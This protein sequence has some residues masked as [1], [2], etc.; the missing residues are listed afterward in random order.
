MNESTESSRFTDPT[1]AVDHVRRVARETAAAAGH[2]A[3]ATAL[4]RVRQEYRVMPL[5]R[6]TAPA[7]RLATWD[8]VRDETRSLVPMASGGTVD[9]EMFDQRVATPASQPLPPQPAWAPDPMLGLQAAALRT[10]HPTASR[11]A[12]LPSPTA[13]VDR[14]PAR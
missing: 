7:D 6:S 5:Q 14:G 13:A 1:I 3:A 11:P 9:K 8:A 4:L 10:F 12:P 2:R